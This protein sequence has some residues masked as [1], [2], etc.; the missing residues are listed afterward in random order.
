MRLLSKEYI[1]ERLSAVVGWRLME[2]WTI[3]RVESGDHLRVVEIQLFE[4]ERT[5]CDLI[6]LSQT[7]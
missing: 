1:W 3:I 6:R 2:R 5:A 4:P 7:A